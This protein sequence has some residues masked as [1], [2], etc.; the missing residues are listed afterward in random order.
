[1]KNNYLYTLIEAI[2]SIALKLHERELLEAQARDTQAL[3]EANLKGDRDETE[4][5]QK[6]MTARM[7]HLRRKAEYKQFSDQKRNPEALMKLSQYDEENQRED[8]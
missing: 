5:I 4:K 6:R 1:M 7:G 3:N 2:E 8:S